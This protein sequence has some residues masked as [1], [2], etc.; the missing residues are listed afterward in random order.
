VYADAHLIIGHEAEPAHHLAFGEG[1]PLLGKLP[2][3][4]IASNSL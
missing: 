2:P 1:R 4:T 3:D